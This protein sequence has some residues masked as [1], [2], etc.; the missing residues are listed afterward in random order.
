MA[1]FF[2]GK[3]LSDELFQK[4]SL[5][6]LKNKGQKVLKNLRVQETTANH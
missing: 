1:I 5:N 3:K 4:Y 2:R 6:D